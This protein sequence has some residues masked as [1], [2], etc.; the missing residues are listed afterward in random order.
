MTGGDY[1]LRCQGCRHM[2]EWTEKTAWEREAQGGGRGRAFMC[3]HPGRPHP[4]R[5]EEYDEPYNCCS[6]EAARECPRK[7]EYKS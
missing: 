6:T 5:V 3:V 7:L 1:A 2:R 4:A